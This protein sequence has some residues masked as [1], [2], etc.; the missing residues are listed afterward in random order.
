MSTLTRTPNETLRHAAGTTTAHTVARILATYDRA[1]VADREAGARWYEVARN[2]ARDL[3]MNPTVG[4]LEYAAAILSAYSP[5]TTWD[6]NRK[7]ARHFATTGTK[8]GPAMA[9]NHERAVRA[10][11]STSPIAEL[12]GPKV[13]RFA[14]NI[15]GDETAVTVDVWA[16]RIALGHRP[17]LDKVIA[18][19]G[20]Y[21]ALE[22]A[23]QIA[24]ERRGETPARMQAITWVVAR[25]GRAS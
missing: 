21:D 1:T 9:T 20:V 7:A 24:A 23:Y 18:R 17:D 10:L 16:A 15:I 8:Y 5:R 3:A 6:R 22:R 11:A 12:R 19:T 25:N 14:R 13:T 2:E 4:S